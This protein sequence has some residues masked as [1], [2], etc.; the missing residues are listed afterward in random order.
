MESYEIT[1]KTLEKPSTNQGTPCTIRRQGCTFFP[2]L[3][4]SSIVR[5]FTDPKQGLQEMYRILKPNGEIVVLE[6][7]FPKNMLLQWLYRYYFEKI[8]PITGQIIS[9]HKIAYSYLPSSVIN[10]PQGETFKK[11]LECSGFKYI[12]LKPLTLGIVT[13]YKGIKNV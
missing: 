11:M 2:F 9:G 12:S 5:N 3:G 13:L 6:F 8:L 4:F 1:W 10:F 7:S